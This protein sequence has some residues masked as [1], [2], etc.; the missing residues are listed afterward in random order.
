MHLDNTRVYTYVRLA[1][2]ALL[3]KADRE[4]T[5]ENNFKV[6]LTFY[7]GIQYL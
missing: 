7:K 4:L 1:T 2:S 3:V 5:K 6:D